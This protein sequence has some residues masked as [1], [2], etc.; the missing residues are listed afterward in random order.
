MSENQ[1][2]I[3]Y[4]C[5]GIGIVI[6]GLSYGFLPGIQQEKS[7]LAKGSL[8]VVSVIIWPI[9]LGIILLSFLGKAIE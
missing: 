8:F 3:T 1:V 5:T 4:I 9:I 2:A 7:P 6:P